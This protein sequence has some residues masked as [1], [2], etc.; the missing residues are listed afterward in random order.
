MSYS[1]KIYDPSSRRKVFQASF[2]RA[3]SCEKGRV[4]EEK[5]LSVECLLLV[6]RSYAYVTP[7]GIGLW[8]RRR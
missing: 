4:A 2:D 5:P 7:G 8:R 3:F 1:N 6:I